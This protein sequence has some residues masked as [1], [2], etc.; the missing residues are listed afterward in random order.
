L[1]IYRIKLT[2]LWW[3]TIWS[4]RKRPSDCKVSWSWSCYAMVYEYPKKIY[5][6]TNTSLWMKILKVLKSLNN[7]IQTIYIF[8]AEWTTAIEIIKGSTS[9]T[10]FSSKNDDI[11]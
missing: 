6:L 9:N 10:V 7:V 11:K 1:W 5:L 3:C 4:L 2:C 8:K